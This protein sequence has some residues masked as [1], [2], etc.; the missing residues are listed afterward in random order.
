LSDPA[1][2]RWEGET[3]VLEVRLQP[4]AGANAIVGIG[5]G[6]LRVRVS[7]APVDDAANQKM[8][9]LLAKEFRVAKSRVRLLAG[10]RR[11]DKRVA[12]ERPQRKPEWLAEI[13]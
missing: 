12:V 13:R 3:L 7:A 6:R 2:I 8:M 11:R 1:P 10:A 9:A 4:R 5:N